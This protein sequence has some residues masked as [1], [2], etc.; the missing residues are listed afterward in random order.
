MRQHRLKEASKPVIAEYISKTMQDFLN[1]PRR[2]SKD[3]R[4][5]PYLYFHPMHCAN[6]FTFWCLQS[7]TIWFLRRPRELHL[8]N[9]RLQTAQHDFHPTQLES[10]N[11]FH[12]KTVAHL[13][14]QAVQSSVARLRFGALHLTLS[15][16][17]AVST[18]RTYCPTSA[19][20]CRCRWT[21]NSTRTV[22]TDA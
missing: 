15:S 17:Q 12:R 11:I 10:T 2:L 16:H 21:I 22:S 7:K 8:F 18:R 1:Q 4:G 13:H 3:K 5:K 9:R 20:H 6:R 19:A 14:W